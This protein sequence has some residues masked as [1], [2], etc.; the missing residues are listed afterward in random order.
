[1]DGVLVDSE[2]QHILTDQQTLEHFGVSVSRTELGGFTGL[3]NIRFYDLMRHKYEIRTT[4]DELI[5]YKNRLLVKELNTSTIAMEGL[6]SMQEEISP[7]I[8]RR[9][10]ASSSFR[11][12]VDVVL[13]KTGL[14]NWFTATVAGDEVATAKPDPA[15]F[16]KTA[17]LLGIA[18][19]NCIVVE[20]SK[21][22]I[23]SALAAGMKVVGFGSPVS[24]SSG[25]LSEADIIISSLRELPQIIRTYG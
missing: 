22:G 23:E 13:T 15:V 7:L 2:P 11:E 10:L 5:R 24:K 6:Y 25:D 12:I 16:L 14:R 4:T 3:D 9:G 17:K 19:E 20:D 1:M 8:R 18:P 21:H